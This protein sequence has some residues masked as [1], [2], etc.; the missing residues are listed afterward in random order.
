MKNDDLVMGLIGFYF[1]IIVMWLAA[2]SRFMAVAWAVPIVIIG[3]FIVAGRW[4]E[5]SVLKRRE[6]KG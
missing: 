3:L 2:T 4:H 6:Q 5:R 1:S